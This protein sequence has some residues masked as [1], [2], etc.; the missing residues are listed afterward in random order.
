MAV[1]VTSRQ[2]VGLKKLLGLA[3]LM[4]R[5][6]VLKVDGPIILDWGN[7]MR[8]QIGP[9]TA[10]AGPVVAL[11]APVGRR[12]RKP[13][14]ATVALIEAMQADRAAG[15]PRSTAAY[16]Q[17]LRTA[18][19]K[20]SE[21]AAGQIVRRE[22]KRIFGTTP[23]SAAKAKGGRTGKRGGGRQPNPA[24]VLLRQKLQEDKAKGDV[25]DAT[26]YLRW[27]V[28]QPGVKI[29]LKG[30]RPIVYRERRLVLG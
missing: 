10:T 12:G 23:R 26:H 4:A 14:A 22:A 21:G 18:D 30:A 7:G 9:V 28:D 1:R 3:A 11:T 19:P 13:T 27:I 5:P 29:G 6:Q 25:R 24:T 2:G 17:V 8:L 20:K 15:A 16:V